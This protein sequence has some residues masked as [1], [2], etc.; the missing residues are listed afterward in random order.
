[1][2]ATYVIKHLP[3][4]VNSMFRN[5]T[6]RDNVRHRIKTQRYQ[7][8]AQA[9]GWDV[10]AAR[11]NWSPEGWY[12]LRILLPQAVARKGNRGDI[13]N[14]IK[15]VSD[16]LVTLGKVPDDKWMAAVSIAYGPVEH[17]TVTVTEA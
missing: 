9:A 1:M 16:L 17:T 12:E 7:T 2:T 3:P 5:A 8:W 15:A 13:D 10:Q 4:S 6:V 11:Q 14:R